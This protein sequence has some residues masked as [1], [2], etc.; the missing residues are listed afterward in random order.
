MLFGGLSNYSGKEL[1]S[2]KE[3]LLPRM[4]DIYPQ[5][6][7]TRV[8]YEWGGSMGI[9]IRRIPL[10]GCIDKNIFYSQGYSGWGVCATHL[11][12]EIMAEGVEGN[13][14]RM[15][16]FE[17]MTH[18]PLPI[19]RWMGNQMIGLGMIYFKFLDRISNF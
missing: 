13:F 7:G 17:K 11:A 1:K 6:E 3:G 10:I 2:I 18:I 15:E 16:L 4:L 9:V 5:L 8:D 14:D 19:G 12:G